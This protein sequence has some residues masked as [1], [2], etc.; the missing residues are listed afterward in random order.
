[1]SLLP[2]G[3]KFQMA[4]G[5]TQQDS[6]LGGFGTLDEI[7][8]LSEVRDDLAILQAWNPDVQRVNV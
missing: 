7:D 2:V 3:T 8:K 1:M 5:A 6:H 4:M